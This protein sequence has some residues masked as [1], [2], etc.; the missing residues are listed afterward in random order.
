MSY[1]DD[2]RFDKVLI[3]SI[4]DF[5][6]EECD[7]AYQLSNVMYHSPKDW[8]NGGYTVVKIGLKNGFLSEKLDLLDLLNN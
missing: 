2:I 6:I 3:S 1:V 8:A 4:Y 7:N 5:L